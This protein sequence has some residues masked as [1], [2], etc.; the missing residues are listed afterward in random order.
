M[1]SEFQ[2]WVRWEEEIVSN[3][4]GRR[5][6]HYYVRDDCGGRD[7]AVVG[8]EKS[9]RHMAY[10]VPAKFYQSLIS[11]S[12]TAS[13]S[14]VN[15]AAAAL[16]SD[17]KL[18]TRRQVVDWLSLLVS[19]STPYGLDPVLDRYSDD[20]DASPAS[21]PVSKVLSSGR[22]RHHSEEFS[23]LGS[24]WNCKKRRKH[25]QSFC[26]NGITISVHDFIYVLSEDN[27]RLV[28]Y[29]EDLYE[30]VKVNNMV[31]VRW[32]HKVDEISIVLPPDTNDR[33]IFF[34]LCLQDVSVECVDGLASVLGFEDFD[35]FQKEALH[36]YS[37]WEPFLCRRQIDKEEVKTFDITQ[38]QGYW[39]QDLLRSMYPSCFKLRLKIK[40][41]GSTVDGNKNSFDFQGNCKR[42]PLS[43]S[44]GV[45][46][47]KSKV[48]SVGNRLERHD[49]VKSSAALFR[50]GLVKQVDSQHQNL[51]TSGLGIEVLS[52]DSG[53]RGCWFCCVVLKRRR[54]R[55]KV[56]YRDVEDADGTGNLEE[57]VSTSRIATT[58]KL[59]IHRSGRRMVRP[60][61]PK[62]DE[63]FCS[64][65]V[66]KAVDA[67][68]HDGWWEGI[69]ISNDS[70]GKIHVYFPGE[71]QVS[72]FRPAD[73]RPSQ[74]WVEN[75]WNYIKARPDIATLLL[76]ELD[77]E[78][79]SDCV[80]FQASPSVVQTEAA[81]R[82]EKG[83]RSPPLGRAEACRSQLVRN[84]LLVKRERN[85]SD[86]VGSYFHDGLRWSS[87]RK[88]KFCSSKRRR[89][90]FSHKCSDKSS[91]FIIPKSLKVVEQDNCKSGGDPLFG[92]PMTFCSNLV[93]T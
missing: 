71:Q 77:H 18:R 14:G 78:K 21:I 89:I 48:L 87:S 6:V 38:V 16:P 12:D 28:A 63:S 56:Q 57:W 49:R 73:L 75:K 24:S 46:D 90:D 36:R 93:M 91:T 92:A 66:G 7:L 35:K 25:Y 9:V 64:Y 54:D 29:I 60:S 11:L 23:W 1:D 53:I 65:E 50:R 84:P 80:T 85:E 69:V 86:L 32:F 44:G 81:P 17:L 88:R 42:K 2:V 43:N 58:D 8:R 5:E 67:W 79:C 62:K 39:G 83:D 31:A 47:G 41:H 13:P 74:D 82:Q 26:R 19:D 30:D 37:S 27:K 34:S 59:G 55:I 61:P 4:R 51:I 3:D 15:S 45:D 52:Q 40:G 10:A 22:M 76:S 70:E 72:S 33:E 68:L 20:E